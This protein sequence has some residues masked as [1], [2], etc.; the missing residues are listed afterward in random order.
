MLFVVSAPAAWATV[1]SCE[2]VIA[3]PSTYYGKETNVEC[4]YLSTKKGSKAVFLNSTSD[5]KKGFSLVIWNTY[6]S[7][8]PSS[9]ETFYLNK[10]LIVKGVVQQH[11]ARP[12]GAERPQILLKDTSQI[13]S[14]NQ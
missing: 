2:Q 13:L 8:F 14:I 12:T 10:T 1:V 9:P 7:K 5:W 11:L 4:T 3:S 6:A